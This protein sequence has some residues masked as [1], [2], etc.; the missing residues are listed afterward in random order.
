MH[1]LE[2]ATKYELFIG[3]PENA[4]VDKLA[5]GCKLDLLF[6]DRVILGY[7]YNIVSFSFDK[8]GADV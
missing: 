2:M 5:F 7:N 6:R 1:S 3:T 8:S 4:T